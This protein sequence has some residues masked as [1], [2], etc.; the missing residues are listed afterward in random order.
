V[1]ELALILGIIVGFL[2]GGTLSRLSKLDFP[3]YYLILTAFFIQFIINFL[4]KLWAAPELA[5][6]LLLCSYLLLLAA[7]WL[8]RENEF[9]FLVLIGL[10]LNFLVIAIN[11]GMPVSFAAAKILG[12]DKVRFVQELAFDYKHVPLINFTKLK[13]LADI[14]PLPKPYPLPGIFSVG[15]VFIS[16]GIFFY[17]QNFM[18]YR[19]KHQQKNTRHPERSEGSPSS[20]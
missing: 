4:M 11:G 18:I 6:F 12:V 5:L 16:V 7:V 3:Y 9:L 20:E 2:R 17:V 19:G 1:L 13:F 10:L 8:N 15:D 14:I